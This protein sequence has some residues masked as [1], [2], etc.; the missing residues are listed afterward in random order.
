[1]ILKLV[2]YNLNKKLHIYL[3]GQP[4]GLQFTQHFF[5][6]WCILATEDEMN[7]FTTVTVWE[8]NFV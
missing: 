2:K 4:W 6:N 8:N 5:H 3:V 1:M 7:L